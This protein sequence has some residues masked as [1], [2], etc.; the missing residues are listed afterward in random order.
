MKIGT[1]DRLSTNV[2][3]RR[4]P[5]KIRALADSTGVE[6]VVYEYGDYKANIYESASQNS[7]IEITDG[8]GVPIYAI[9]S[10]NQKRLFTNSENI[11][12]D[13][14]CP[15][16]LKKLIGFSVPSAFIHYGDEEIADTAVNALAAEAEVLKNAGIIISDTDNNC[17]NDL[18]AEIN[19]EIRKNYK[20]VQR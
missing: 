12:N 8:K 19:A 7:V 20:P 17:S 9:N 16:T 18:F 14:A 1:Y 5:T 11:L 10:E 15:S 13:I 4:L 3:D 2:E 6:P